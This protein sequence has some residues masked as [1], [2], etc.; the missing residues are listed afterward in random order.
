MS[1][2]RWL[3]K[4]NFD[5]ILGVEGKIKQNKILSDS[6]RGM[7]IKT[8]EIS[9]MAADSAKSRPAN[10]N[11]ELWPLLRVTI[12]KFTSGFNVKPASSRIFLL[13]FFFLRETFPGFLFFFFVING[14]AMFSQSSSPQLKFRFVPP[15]KFRNFFVCSDQNYVFFFFFAIKHSRHYFLKFKSDFLVIV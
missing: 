13:F 2:N 7:K 12:A 1:S 4:L 15:S 8:P 11:L 14:L 10:G 5:K 3:S 6:P 9:K